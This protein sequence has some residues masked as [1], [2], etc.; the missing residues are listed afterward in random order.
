MFKNSII[1]LNV[2]FVARRNFGVSNC[3]LARRPPK[4]EY[5]NNQFHTRKRTADPFDR[6]FSV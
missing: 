3:L 1:K 5:E 6:F 4:E 2:L